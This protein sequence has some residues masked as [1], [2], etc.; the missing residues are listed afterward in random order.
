NVVGRADAGA[1]V[2]EGEKLDAACERQNRPRAHAEH[3]RCDVVRLRDERVAGGHAL[4]NQQF[5]AAKQFLMLQFLVGETDQRLERRLVAEPV[6]ATH[7]EHLRADEPFDEPEHVGV[8]APLHLAEETLLLDVEN[9]DFVDARQAVG[10]VLQVRLEEAVADDV[11]VDVPADAPGHLDAPGV[12]GRSG[13]MSGGLHGG[14]STGFASDDVSGLSGSSRT[15][16][17]WRMPRIP[18]ERTEA[19]AKS[20]GRCPWSSW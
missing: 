10:Q 11:A 18:A 7:F 13:G 4:G 1:V 9:V 3:E 14:T 19:R 6:I 17:L 12:A 5:D 2:C 16:A 20:W 8:G 15:Q